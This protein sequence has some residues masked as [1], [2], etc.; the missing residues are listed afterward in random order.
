M[1]TA[2]IQS[3][4]NV[5]QRLA[6]FRQRFGVKE[7][8]LK[9]LDAVLN[10]ALRTHVHRVVWLDLTAV[11]HVVPADDVFTFRTLN[12][13]EVAKFAEDPSYFIDPSLIEG[14]RSGRE[15]CF[16]ALACDRLAAFGCYTLGYV[17]PRQAAGAAIS[18]P[19]DVAYMSYG[20]THPDFRGFR[21]HGIAMALALQELAK[22]GITKLVSIVS[23]TNVASLK[24]CERLGYISLGNMITIGT[25][26]HALGFY[27]EAA[28]Q[29]GVRFGRKAVKS[30]V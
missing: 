12:A 30:K 29:L 18:F 7:T 6:S 25:P 27:P 2:A 5:F 13:D 20:F 11:A 14:V 8:I 24:S 21:L 9:S 23:W 17:E 26:N 10:K 4:P 28:K 3:S 19:S 15:V 1:G 16:A 22:R